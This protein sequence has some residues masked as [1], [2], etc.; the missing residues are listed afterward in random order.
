MFSTMPET[1]EYAMI[2]ARNG[3]TGTVCLSGNGVVSLRWPRHGGSIRHGEPAPL[4]RTVRTFDDTAFML[5]MSDP[6]ATLAFLERAL[7]LR[8]A[9][10]LESLLRTTLAEGLGKSIEPSAHILPL[11]TEPTTLLATQHGILLAGGPEP[12]AAIDRLHDVLRDSFRQARVTERT[13]DGRF[14]SRDIRSGGPRPAEERDGQASPWRTRST[15]NPDT[16]RGL[17]SATRDGGTY[18]IAT[19]RALLAKYLEGDLPRSIVFPTNEDAPGS[20]V[21]AGGFAALPRIFVLAQASAFAPLLRA[22]PLLPIAHSGAIVWS[23][24]ESGE[25]T[26]LVIAPH[27]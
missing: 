15:V 19:D 14:T 6:P 26:Q 16:E 23:L 3:Q 22:A 21:T 9:T 4:P 20:A 27:P 8:T 11:L 2:P 24:Q 12:R 7:D 18:V 17:Y 1:I 10:L 13:L 25:E 5:A